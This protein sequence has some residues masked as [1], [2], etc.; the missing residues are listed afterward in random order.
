MPQFVFPQL[1]NPITFRASAALAGAG[2]WDAAPL[3]IAVPQH[4][5]LVLFLSYTRGAAGGAFDFQLVVSP[6]SA[7]VA[8]V[9]NWFSE[10]EFTPAVLAAGADSQSRIQRE[11]VTYLSQ[12]VP[13][14][15]FVY[16]PI[17][18]GGGIERLRIPARESG[19]AGTPGTLHIVGIVYD[20]QA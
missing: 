19:I 6:Y 11:Y 4:G 16:G 20:E 13:I 8:V 3:E 14:E 7:V 12:G 5:R 18:L 9:Q 10:S 2:A 1:T 17:E 15:N